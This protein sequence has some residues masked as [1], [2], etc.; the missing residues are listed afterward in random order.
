MWERKSGDTML[1]SHNY[2]LCIDSQE[3]QGKGLIVNACQ[4]GSPT[5]K[6]SFAI[7]KGG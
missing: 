7:S 2:E 4:E 1:K 6:W 3:V 5:Q